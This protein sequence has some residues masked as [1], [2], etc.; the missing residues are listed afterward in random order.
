MANSQAFGIVRDTFFHGDDESLLHHVCP[1]TDGG[2][3]L[4]PV[5]P[6]REMRRDLMTRMDLALPPN[7]AARVGRDEMEMWII[8]N[9]DDDRP[10]DEPRRA[11][12][13]PLIRTVQGQ[14]VH[15]RVGA[16]VNTHTI[17][18][19][20]IEPTAANDGVGKHSFEINGNFVYQFQTNEA[21]T[22][23]YHCH[24][25][26]TLHF[27][28]GLWGGFV[29]DPKNPNITEDN[30]LSDGLPFDF[31]G[32]TPP[33]TTFGPGYAA[34]MRG[35]LGLSEGEAIPYHQE[36]IW[37]VDSLQFNW[38]FPVPHHNHNM[39]DCDANDP[40]G[41]DTFYKFGSSGEFELNN[42]DPDIFSVTGVVMN[43]E[44]A[45]PF[46]GV[47][48][49]PAIAINAAAGEIVLLRYVNASYTIQELRLPVDAWVIAWDGHPLGT[50]GFHQFS[51]PTRFLPAQPSGPPA[52]GALTLSSTREI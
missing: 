17:H 20:G 21:G 37:A 9:N 15:A 4:D 42:F 5:T 51:S 36:R 32:L 27:H 30:D 23:F 34:G 49:N 8:E 7:V 14:V 11:Y 35:A 12:P 39:Q 3:P 13:S 2:G 29:V 28:M 19:H 25:N 33:Y 48:D 38:H 40:A 16:S 41:A 31:T 46:T 45:R 26:T 47:I 18:W 22:Y 1:P 24:K 10:D 50:G 52:P 44:T 6:D 43:E